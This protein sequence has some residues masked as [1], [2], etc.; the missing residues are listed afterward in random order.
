MKEHN[1]VISSILFFVILLIAIVPVY[2]SI[3]ESYFNTFE[4]DNILPYV[5]GNSSVTNSLNSL[6]DRTE[7][8]KLDYSLSEAV[9]ILESLKDTVKNI[10]SDDFETNYNILHDPDNYELG[11]YYKYMKSPVTWIERNVVHLISIYSSNEESEIKQ[12]ID[13]LYEMGNEEMQNHCK[14]YDSMTVVSDLHYIKNRFSS[15]I[16]DYIDFVVK[17]ADSDST[18]YDEGKLP[19][20]GKNMSDYYEEYQKQQEEENNQNSEFEEENDNV[21]LEEEPIVV[22]VPNVSDDIL[23]SNDN[24]NTDNNIT[25]PSYNVNNMGDY[26]GKMND[27]S[28]GSYIEVKDYSI[29]NIYYTFD[30]STEN[31]IWNDTGISME[32]EKISY[33]KL[34]NVLSTIGRNNDYFYMTDSD[35]VMLIAEGEVLVL[36]K[37]ETVT[38]DEIN[39]LFD[40]FEKLGIK[41]MLKSDE[42]VNTQNS[43]SSKIEAGEVNSISVNDN[44]L[45]LTNKPILKKNILQ[46]PIKQVAEALGYQVTESG[47]TITLVYE[48]KNIVDTSQIEEDD[49]ENNNNTEQENSNTIKIILTIGSNN[50]T[51]NDSKNSFKTPVTQENGITYCEFDKIANKLGYSY[52]YDAD[53]GVIKFER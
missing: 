52:S 23:S 18:N 42:T 7:N 19:E 14:T 45:I 6:I 2:A 15:S 32:D 51:I 29:K 16:S 53:S 50:F 47:K 39:N 41:V 24:I 28:N 40:K 31:P 38:E 10:S 35:M 44:K 20:D 36:N 21:V 17:K 12:V 30:K 1:K 13:L 22:E 27:I 8:L 37:V 5:Y 46:L 48:D 11:A 3:G 33:E 25:S 26:I 43:L 34:L 4:K 9:S 49:I